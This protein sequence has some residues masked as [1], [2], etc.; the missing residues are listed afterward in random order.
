[1]PSVTGNAN[2]L[3]MILT[4]C[5]QSLNRMHTIQNMPLL[6]NFGSISMIQKGGSK[7]RSILDCHRSLW[8][9]PP[10]NQALSAVFLPWVAHIWEHICSVVLEVNFWRLLYLQRDHS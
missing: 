9:L 10:G 3:V 5:L 8:T 1:M 2:A 7:N 6:C 4:E